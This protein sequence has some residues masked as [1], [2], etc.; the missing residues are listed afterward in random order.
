M[1]TRISEAEYINAMAIITQYKAENGNILVVGDI[2][3]DYDK[4]LITRQGIEIYL[5]KYEYSLFTLLVENKGKILSKMDIQ[6]A[7][8]GIDFDTNTNNI[9][10]YIAFLRKKI[11]KPFT[12]NVICTKQGYY[13]KPNLISQVQ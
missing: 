5:T 10:V 12:T 2:T 11:D 3:I 13:F 8:W 4:R 9:E 1:N 6:K 7:V